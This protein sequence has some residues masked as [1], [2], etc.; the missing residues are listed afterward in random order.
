[1][2]EMQRLNISGEITNNT[3]AETTVGA[4][5]M[6]I[7]NLTAVTSNALVLTAILRSPQLRNSLTNVFVVNL[8]LVD[9]LG[10]LFVLP[11]SAASFIIN[12]WSFGDGLCT[13]HAFFTAF[14]SF[15]S[16]LS[17]SVISVERFYSIKRPM[18]YAAHVT[19]CK[20]YTVVALIWMQSMLFA[21][22]LLFPWGGENGAEKTKYCTF[23]WDFDKH[24]ETY[25][26]IVFT[27]C[28]VLPGISLLIM[29]IGV[30]KVAHATRMQI[31]PFLNPSQSNIGKN[32]CGN[33]Q[34]NADVLGESSSN[35][36]VV[37]QE[38]TRK[39]AN[40]QFKA[41]RTLMLLFGMYLVLWGPYYTLNLCGALYDIEHIQSLELGLLWLGYSSFAINPFL[42][43]WMNRSIREELLKMYYS[44]RCK[45]RDGEAGN[46]E[47]D[48]FGS[49]EDFL[50]FLERTTCS[51]RVTTQTG[52]NTRILV[53]P[54]I[55]KDSL[56][57]ISD[58]SEHPF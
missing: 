23:T 11:I 28:Y 12:K 53:E 36:A 32:Q 43:G 46:D 14:F 29:Y 22:L 33:T 27:F 58:L 57:T 10:S 52:G 17:L 37:M 40:G 7:V 1:M 45:S 18:H 55:A 42:Y 20:V 30:F 8:C 49:K 44:I 51:T 2:E 21:G 6:A 5:L 38:T 34:G 15:A 16:T 50:Q 26:S 25:I 19:P 54:P 48:F 31:H 13:C 4:M 3:Y 9:L 41:L 24:S 56:K 47:D 35:T 39:K